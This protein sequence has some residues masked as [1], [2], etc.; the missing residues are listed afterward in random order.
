E[1]VIQPIRQGRPGAPPPDSAALAAAATPR[2]PGYHDFYIAYDATNHRDVFYGAGGQ[3]YWIYDVTDLKNP[4]LLTSIT[5]VAGVRGGH[6]FQ[7]EATGRYAV[8][9]TE[10]QYQPLRLF[11]LKPG[12]DG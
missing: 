6:T 1:A 9:E 3:G 12:L 4:K 8:T 10:S 2:Q 5:G 11:D 7:V